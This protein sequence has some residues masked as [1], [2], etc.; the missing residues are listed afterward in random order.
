MSFCRNCNKFVSYGMGTAE[1]QGDLEL[2]F[3]GD[4]FFLSGTV[5]IMLPCYECEEELRESELEVEYEGEH[6]CTETTEPEFELEDMATQVEFTERTQEKDRHGKRI[7]NP[8]YRRKYYGAE[9]NTVVRCTSCD[10]LISVH[11]E[12]ETQARYMEEV[13]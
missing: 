2:S 8:R 7:T 9:L 11:E 6:L 4:K 10:E 5:R 13:Y 3:E 1:L 12:M